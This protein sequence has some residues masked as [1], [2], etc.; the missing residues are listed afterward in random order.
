MRTRVSKK[1][2]VRLKDMAGESTSQIKNSSLTEYENNLALIFWLQHRTSTSLRI[3]VRNARG[4]DRGLKQRARSKRYTHRGSRRNPVQ[5]QERL[6][7]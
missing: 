6:C 7:H 4:P 1:K 3:V 5:N 2:F